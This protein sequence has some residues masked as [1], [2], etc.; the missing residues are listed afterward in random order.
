MEKPLFGQLEAVHKRNRTR[1]LWLFSEHLLELLYLFK[2]GQLCDLSR[3]VRLDDDL[4]GHH[5]AKAVFEPI[6]VSQN[7]VFLWQI[8]RDI[9]RHLHLGNADASQNQDAS[10][11]DIDPFAVVTDRALK[12]VNHQ[13]HP[14][15]VQVTHMASARRRQPTEHRRNDEQRDKEHR[16]DVQRRDD[17]KLLQNITRGEHK[18][19]KTKGR[20][21]VGHEGRI[22]HLFDHPR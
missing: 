12:S 16:E 2:E 11:H 17:A 14:T 9:A 1:E 6:Q 18:S 8:A 10:R 15:A 21:G 13:E 19:R 20:S 4:E 22:A 5:T 3:L 7:R